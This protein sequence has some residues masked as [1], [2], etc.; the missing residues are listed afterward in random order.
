MLLAG[1]SLDPVVGPAGQHDCEQRAEGNRDTLSQPHRPLLPVRDLRSIFA[2]LGPQRGTLHPTIGRP[3]LGGQEG[4]PA[5]NGCST[6][7]IRTGPAGCFNWPLAR[8]K[9]KGHQRP[10]MEPA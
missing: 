5:Y 2:S 10:V 3:Q 1:R 7:G 9:M 8:T 4:R 6:R